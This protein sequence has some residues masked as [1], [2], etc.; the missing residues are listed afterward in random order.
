MPAN[1]RETE[2]QT[3]TQRAGGDGEQTQERSPDGRWQQI[4]SKRKWRLPSIGLGITSVLALSIL[5]R[6]RIDDQ[7]FMFL[8]LPAILE[9]FAAQGML[10]RR[11]PLP[12]PRSMG[13][14]TFLGDAYFSSSGGGLRSAALGSAWPASRVLS[15]LCIQEPRWRDGL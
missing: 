14:K 15:S 3:V 9:V 1:D 12:H 8:G 10:S 13:L 11:N 5:I 4:V 7:F 2:A 6:G